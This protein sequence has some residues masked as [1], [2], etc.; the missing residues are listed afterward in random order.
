MGITLDPYRLLRLYIDDVGYLLE[1]DH[2][3][4]IKGH[5]RARRYD[6]LAEISSSIGFEYLNPTAVAVLRQAEAFFKKNS[7]FAQEDRCVKN[8]RESFLRAERMCK[9]TNKRLL[10]FFK[11]EDRLDQDLDRQIMIMRKVISRTLRS[12]STFTDDIPSLVKVTAGATSHSSRAESIP[13]MKIHKRNV[14]TQQAA[15]YYSALL[16]YWGYS[17]FEDKMRYTQANRVTL[18]PKS[19][20]THRSIAAEPTGNLPFQLAC[21][22]YIK[23]RLE[24]VLGINLRDQKRNQRLA[25]EASLRDHLATVDLSMASDTLSLELVPYLFPTDWSNMLLD[26][27]TP[28]FTGVFGEGKYEK[29]SSMGNGF[30]FTVETLVF[31]AAAIA[32]GSRAYSVY[33]DDIII[34]SALVN[35]LS[36]LLKYLGFVF[37]HEKSFSAGPFRE[38]CGCDYFNGVNV[39]PFYLRRN[40]NLNKPELCHVVNGL[41]SASSPEGLLAKELKRMVRSFQLPLVPLN[42]DSTSGIFIDVHSAYSMKKLFVSKSDLTRGRQFF[43]GYRTITKTRR[44]ANTR[45]YVLWFIYKLSSPDK[46]VI[47]SEVNRG[48]SVRISYGSVAWINPGLGNHVHLYWWTDFLT[49]KAVS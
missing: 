18:V 5:I 38:S 22:L 8:A 4:L 9:R 31:T 30:T 6:L 28:E 29:F 42:E 20:K 36:K 34:E 13:Y 17:A 48:N 25:K 47:S 14:V 49:A 19:W 1:E 24:K 27:R 10:H 26:L 12:A 35:K 23:S 37:N 11:H 43:K 32:V 16:R 39:R 46:E 2:V 21:D 44:L 15:P 41:A 45:T 40:D 33:G 3:R 7:T